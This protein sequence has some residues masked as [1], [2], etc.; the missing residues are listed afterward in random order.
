MTFAQ[1]ASSV[2]GFGGSSLS[3]MPQTALNS[4][5][6]MRPATMPSTM[7]NGL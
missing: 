7:P 1:A 3:K 2:V 5:W 6:L 4:F